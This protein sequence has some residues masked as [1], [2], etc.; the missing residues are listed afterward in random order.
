MANVVIQVGGRGWPI[1]CRAG[2]EPR[3]EALGRMLEARWAAADRASGGSPER[4]ML[5]V[6]LMLADALDEAE[7]RPPAG[8]A[9][10]EVALA[11]IADRLESLADALEMDGAAA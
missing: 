3:V 11:R 2:E 1:A 10:S 8:A 4:A 9:L 6:A 5:L 7:S